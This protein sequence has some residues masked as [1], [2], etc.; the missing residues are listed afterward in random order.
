MSGHV[1]RTPQGI[2]PNNE[3]VA[4]LHHV[5]LSTYASVLVRNGFDDMETLMEIEDADLRAL[6]VP[7]YHTVRLRKSLQELRRQMG[8]AEETDPNHPVVD[9]LNSIGLGKYASVL[10]KSG[11]DDMETLALVEDSDLKDMGLPRGHAVKL[12]KRLHAHELEAAAIDDRVF[13][14][15]RQVSSRIPTPQTPTPPAGSSAHSTP[16]ASAAKQKGG[17]FSLGPPHGRQLPQISVNPVAAVRMS[18]APAGPLPSDQMKSAV[19]QSWDKVQ[20]QGSFV[21]GEL[22]YRYTF[23]LD[24][25]AKELFPVHVRQKYRE[26]TADELCAEEEEDIW[27]SAALKRLFGKFVN[28]IGCTVAGLNEMTKL[29][30][31]LSKLGARHVQYR[32]TEERWEVL[33]K[34]LDLTLRDIL[35]KDY[36][37]EVQSA[38]TSVY[39]FMAS[40]MIDGL[41]QAKAAA[42]LQMK[43]QP[44]SRM[45]SGSLASTTVEEGEDSQESSGEPLGAVAEE[46]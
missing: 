6:G 17:Q 38:W 3:V 28:A 5:G 9:F 2:D 7:L 44:R 24:P 15:K 40:I 14:S 23:K 8:G 25:Q 37:S 29:V 22:L 33:G 19:E 20:A 34:A 26:W 32:V 39:G 18:T 11:F 27:Q 36:T 30:P 1:P 4:F 21:V 46:A 43:G 31:M 16:T 10:I 35:K 45:N 12:R 13:Y 41:R 42:A